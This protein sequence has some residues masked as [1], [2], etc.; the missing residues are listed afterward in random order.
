MTQ[1]E[2]AQRLAAADDGLSLEMWLELGGWDLVEQYERDHYGYMAHDMLKL[3]RG[4]TETAYKNAQQ[5][6][7]DE[8][9]GIHFEP[10]VLEVLWDK[11]DTKKKWSKK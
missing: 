11:S 4:A 7:V 10:R 6:L 9:D 5:A 8:L 3:M 2:L 1:D